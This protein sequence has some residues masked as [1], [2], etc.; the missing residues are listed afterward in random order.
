MRHLDDLLYQQLLSEPAR[1]SAETWAHLRSDC[2]ECAEFLR[3]RTSVDKIDG[4]VDEVL[5]GLARTRQAEAKSENAP[6]EEFERILRA[7]RPRIS[8]SRFAPLAAF[9]AGVLVLVAYFAI[10]RIRLSPSEYDGTKGDSTLTLASS[11]AVVGADKNVRQGQ[12]GTEVKSDEV[13]SVRLELSRA[14]L[15]SL[16]RSDAH[17][18]EVLLLNQPAPI[19]RSDLRQDGRLMGVPLKGLIGEERLRLLASD[20]PLSSEELESLAKGASPPEGVAMVGFTVWV[21]P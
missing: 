20:R 9:V 17:S 3:L 12:S 4:R 8:A 16:V 7:T 21:R 19:G 14:S 18:S 2:P 13:L 15:V 11:F 1:V 5:L 10:W 6:P